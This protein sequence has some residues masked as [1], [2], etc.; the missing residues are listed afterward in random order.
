MEEGVHVILMAPGVLLMPPMTATWRH[1]FREWFLSTQHC[2][3]TSLFLLTTQQ[4]ELFLRSD[5]ETVFKKFETTAHSPAT[6]E[7]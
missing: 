4:V 1:P 7:C 5:E 2:T 6:N 3:G